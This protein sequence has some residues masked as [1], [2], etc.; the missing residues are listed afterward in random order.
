MERALQ[1]PLGDEVLVL[2]RH[3]DDDLRARDGFPSLRSLHDARAGPRH[4]R[5][6]TSGKVLRAPSR[7]TR[8]ADPR[9][10]RMHR[11]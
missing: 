7:W 9:K 8:P 5:W 3:G 4:V 11:P 2:L 6:I 1:Q 10:M